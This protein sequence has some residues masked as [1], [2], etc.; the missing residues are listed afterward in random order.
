M[1]YSD[2]FFSDEDAMGDVLADYYDAGGRVVL[3]VFSNASEPLGGRFGVLAN[4]YQLLDPV[5]QNNLPDSLGV[6]TEPGSPLLADVR[7]FSEGDA[8]ESTGSP[9]N[10]GIV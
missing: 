9:I 6:V 2:E 1:A 5:G 10:G 7:N 4:G 8:Y 3:A